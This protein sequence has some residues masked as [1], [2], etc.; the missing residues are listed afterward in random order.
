[1]D[2]YRPENPE[3]ALDKTLKSFTVFPDT[4]FI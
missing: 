3:S 4:F 1:M 2:S